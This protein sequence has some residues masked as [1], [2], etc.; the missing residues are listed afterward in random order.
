M[1][2]L[3]EGLPPTGESH[4]R[5]VLRRCMPD[6][7]CIFDGYSPRRTLELGCLVD[8]AHPEIFCGLQ[9]DFCPAT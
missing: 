3:A 8:C 1:L 9:H 4:S 2:I 7:D 5:L 6:H